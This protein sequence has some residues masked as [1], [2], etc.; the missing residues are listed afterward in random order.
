MTTLLAYDGAQSSERALEYAIKY[1]VNFN[2]PL[3]VLTVVTKEQMDPEDP[4]PAVREYMEAA[5][6]KAAAQ[7]CRSTP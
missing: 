3:Y 7:G 4:D 2:E 1:A 5:Q 6:K